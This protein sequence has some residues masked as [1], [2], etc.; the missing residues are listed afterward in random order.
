[1]AKSLGQGLADCNHRIMQR[2]PTK[3][4][5]NPDEFSAEGLR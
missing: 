4:K 3:I 1:M 2:Q 5:K